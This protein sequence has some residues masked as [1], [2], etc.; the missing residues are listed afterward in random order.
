MNRS[1]LIVEPSHL[2]GKVF[3]S[4]SKSHAIRSLLFASIAEG[5]SQIENL[6]KSPDI[7]ATIQFCK[8]LGAKIQGN[9]VKMTVEGAGGALQKPSKVDVGNSGLL[10]RLATPFLALGSGQSLITGDRSI[11]TLRHTAPL[12]SALK[13]LGAHIIS[14]G[15]NDRPPLEVEGPIRSGVVKLDGT[16]SQPVSALLITSSILSGKTDIFVTNPG[17][18]PWI[19]LTLSW[20]NKFGVSYT[21]EGYDHYTVMG[22]HRYTGFNYTVPSDYSSLAFLLVAAMITR[23]EI[24]IEGLDMNSV[25]GDKEVIGALQKM[26]GCFEIDPLKGRLTVLKC[27]EIKGAHI[28]VNDMID[29]LPILATL[30]C[31]ATSK[32]DLYNG[33]IARKKESDRIHVINQELTRMGAKIEEKEDGLVIHP[34]KLIGSNVNSHQDH[35]IAMSLAVG[36]LGAKG[37]T[38]IQGASCIAKSYPGFVKDLLA[39]GANVRKVAR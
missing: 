34:S 11:Q 35:R 23:S 5:V 16:D 2:E 39:L 7:D 6:P 1:S 8:S 20:L 29:A 31:F 9:H 18:K 19:D 17:E 10:L 32:T 38:L 3:G 27:E 21:R 14:H 36:G 4:P 28:D 30:A 33:A 26:G 15:N 12:V 37:Q 22:G 25:Q 24:T 13:Q